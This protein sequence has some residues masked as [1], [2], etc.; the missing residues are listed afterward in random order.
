ML[1][2]LFVL[3]G[4]FWPGAARMGGVKAL[5]SLDENAKSARIDLDFGA[6]S[7]WVSGGAQPGTL[8][9]GTSGTALEVKSHLAGDVQEV[10]LDAGPSFL[11]FLGSASGSWDF[12][13]SDSI[14]LTLDVDAGASSMTFDLADLPVQ[15]IRVDGGASTINLTLPKSSKK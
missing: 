10:D 5:V 15:E 4:V 14:P 2:G 8:V 12:Q 1:L 13:L 3:A 9:Y 11:P 6:S 7:L